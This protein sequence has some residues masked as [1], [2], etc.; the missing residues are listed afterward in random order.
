VEQE[1]LMPKPVTKEDLIKEIVTERQLLESE[2]ALVNKRAMTRRGVIG[3]WSAK[4]I[5]AH[6]VAWEQFLLD[7]YRTGL[8]GETPRVS[9]HFNIATMHAMNE[10]IYQQN[11]RRKLEEVLTEF[12]SSYLETLTAIKA[13][14]E[15]DLF[16]S[17][18]SAWTGKGTLA[19]YIRANT[20]NHYRW[21]RTHLH[22]W[23]RS[24]HK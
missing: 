5:M 7:W 16:T 23:L 15:G 6:L 18:R 17:G 11:K 1:E 22:K 13:F 12:A 19:G 21:A 20:S 4:D 2:L 9:P 8:S 10:A 3:D 14:P 24:L